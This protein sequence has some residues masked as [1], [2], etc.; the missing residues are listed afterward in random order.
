M[1]GIFLLLPD[2]FVYLLPVYRYRF[3]CGDSGSDLIAF[4][5]Q[6]SDLDIVTN[7]EGFSWP[8]V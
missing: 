8:S 6:D 4:D 7:L 5:L 2:P 3:G 1:Q